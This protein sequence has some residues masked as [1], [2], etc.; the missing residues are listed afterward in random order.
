M[1][2]AS[3]ERCSTIYSH[4][5]LKFNKAGKKVFGSRGAKCG[6][7][8]WQRHFIFI[9]THIMKKECQMENVSALISQGC[10]LD[11]WHVGALGQVAKLPLYM[12]SNGFLYVGTRTQHSPAPLKWCISYVPQ[13]QMD[14]CYETCYLPCIVVDN[15]GFF[16]PLLPPND[17]ILWAI[18]MKGIG[19]VCIL[20]GIYD[21]R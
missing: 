9:R 2:I 1:M 13:T 17:N 16:W 21:D 4:A 10:Y 7:I 3:S 8:T 6:H 5:Y 12:V 14:G 11:G 18:N 19:L 15:N 20:W